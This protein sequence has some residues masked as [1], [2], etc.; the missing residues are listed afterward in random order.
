MMAG[1]KILCTALCAFKE[2]PRT[3]AVELVLDGGRYV[4]FIVQKEKWGLTEALCVDHM[5]PKGLSP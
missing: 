2:D 4:L 5:A 1:G 3:H